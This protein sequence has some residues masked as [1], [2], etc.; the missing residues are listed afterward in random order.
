MAG[1]E[2]MIP[3]NNF[4]LENYNF[5]VLTADVGGLHTY[6]AVMGVKSKKGYDIILKYSYKTSEIK[7]IHEPINLALKEAHEVYGICVNRCCI[8][9]AGPVSRKRGYIKLT[10][11]DLEINQKNILTNTMLNKVILINDFEAVGYGLDMLNLKKDTYE[12]DHVGEDLTHQWTP[13][14]TYAIIGA[15]TGLGMSIVHYDSGKHLH[16]PLPSEGGHMDFVPY[17]HLELELVEYLKKNHLTKK[18]VHPE[19]ER[20]L[21]G[22]GITILY[23]FLRT[24]SLFSET[25][26]TKKIDSLSDEQKP[27]EI[28]QAASHDETCKK[29]VDMFINFYARAARILALISECYSGLFIAGKIAIKNPGLFK[30]GAFMEEFE[31]HDKRNDILRKTKVY[32]IKNEDIGLYGCC[33]VAANFFNI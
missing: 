24:K 19:Y 27:A 32:I 4:N 5:F 26:T 2:I 30:T 28:F 21:C 23:D 11:Q 17:N 7:Q 8:G 31:K 6:I 9:G 12:L 10:N 25:E 15:G 18:D 33:N 16:I 13:G 14:N 3:Q 22:S 29:V 20:V 1:R